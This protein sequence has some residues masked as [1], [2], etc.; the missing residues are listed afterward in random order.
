MLYNIALNRDCTGRTG[1]L[2]PFSNVRN[3]L[4]FRPIKSGNFAIKCELL[5]SRQ[6]LEIRIVKV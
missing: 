6:N 3:E 2:W 4:V 1:R 5:T